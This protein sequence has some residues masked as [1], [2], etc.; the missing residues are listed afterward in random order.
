MTERH[1]LPGGLVAEDIE[2]GEGAEC[3]HGATVKVHYRG[4]LEDGTQFDSSYDRGEPI[5]FP[6]SSL[7]QGWQIG[8][9]GMKE[10]G[11]RRLEVPYGLGYG[12]RGAPPS[13]PPRANLIFDIELLEV[14]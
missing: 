5:T 14:K 8:I 3:P 10:G 9:P 12:E 6:L 13:I 7:I 2:K 1:E 11:K 4:T